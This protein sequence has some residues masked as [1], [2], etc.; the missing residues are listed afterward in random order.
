ME[1]K[2]PRSPIV[3]FAASDVRK[4]SLITTGSTSAPW[5]SIWLSSF[6]V[7]FR[8]TWLGTPSSRSSGFLSIVGMGNSRLS[9]GPTMLLNSAPCWSSGLT[10][11]LRDMVV[12][13][14]DW[15]VD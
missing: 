12:Q 9:M 6:S 2:S 10:M 11:P 5:K 7:V 13:E 3:V 4:S 15:Q 14:V 8:D 1:L